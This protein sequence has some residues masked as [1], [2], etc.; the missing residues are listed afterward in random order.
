MLDFGFYNMDCM[1]GMREFPD[2][3]FDL[4]IVDPPYGSGLTETGGCMG[5]FAKY[6]QADKNKTGRHAVSGLRKNV[7]NYEAKKEEHKENRKKIISW[8]KAPGP[9]YF[10][11]LFRVSRNQVI[12]GGELFPITGDPLFSDLEKNIYL[13]KFFYGNGRICLDEFRLER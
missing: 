4:A 2:N 6:H 11:E 10:E 5:W 9:K 12:W 7:S 13:R 8:D 3:Y 1:D